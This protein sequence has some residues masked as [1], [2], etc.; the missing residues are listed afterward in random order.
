MEESDVDERESVL[1]LHLGA[2]YSSCPAKPPLP[3]NSRSTEGSDSTCGVTLLSA[4]CFLPEDRQRSANSGSG[5]DPAAGPLSADEGSSG[6]AASGPVREVFCLAL[7]HQPKSPAN[8]TAASKTTQQHDDGG[9]SADKLSE[10]LGLMY[11]GVRAIYSPRP[12]TVGAAGPEASEKGGAAEEKAARPP[13]S[14]PR[15]VVCNRLHA[16]L[17]PLYAPVVDSADGTFLVRRLRELDSS[18]WANRLDSI[19]ME[20][21][22]FPQTD[23]TGRCGSSVES[24]GMLYKWSAA[25]LQQH[26]STRTVSRRHRRGHSPHYGD[27][28][29][30]TIFVRG[31]V[32]DAAAEFPTMLTLQSL[33]RLLAVVLRGPSPALHPGSPVLCTQVFECLPFRLTALTQLCREVRG[34]RGEEKRSLAVVIVRRNVCLL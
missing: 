3:H 31:S 23:D 22:A 13:S 5:V 12:S 17:I 34:A 1:A 11:G 25:P 6:S 28:A 4:R 8:R 21:V 9:G 30:Q 7:P 10:A 19:Y 16:G 2:L 14:T 29:S 24:M 32:I 20:V 33:S 26:R 27:C 18:W 15:L